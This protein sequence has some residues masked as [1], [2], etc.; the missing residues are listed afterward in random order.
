ML[1]EKIDEMIAKA[2]KSGNK[3]E[4]DVYRAIKT[5]FTNYRT[6]KAGNELNDSVEVQI[7]SKLVNQHKDSIEQYTNANRLD[8]AE[9]ENAELAILMNFMPKE[10]TAEDIENII[11]EYLATH[12]NVSM[13]NMKDVMTVIKN[14]FPTV[15]GG[16]VSKIFMNKIK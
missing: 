11:N 10:A 5:A 6:A 2:I 1:V 9:K 14:K 8:L 7:I 13:K 16:V 12:D 3:I 15:N 4:L